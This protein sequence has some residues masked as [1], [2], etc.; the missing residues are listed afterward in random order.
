[1]SREERK[2]K[3]EQFKEEVKQIRTSS[4]PPQSPEEAF[5]VAGSRV[6]ESLSPQLGSD[7]TKLAD[8]RF[9]MRRLSILTEPLQAALA[10]F[11]WRG[12]NVYAR[13]KTKNGDRKLVRR[14]VRF[15]GHIE[16]W[17]LNTSPSVKGTGRRQLIEMQ[18]ASTGGGPPIM[19]PEE[20]PGWVGRN[21]TQRDY[22]R[23]WEEEHGY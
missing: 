23:K 20:K 17:Y 21:V 5:E 4:R 1:M 14:G 22:K 8:G 15:W 9:D 19:P 6:A 13:K 11:S 12:K 16:D 2:E 10:Y 3:L 18:R 7:A